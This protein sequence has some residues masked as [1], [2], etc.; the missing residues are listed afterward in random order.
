MSHNPTYRNYSFKCKPKE[1]EAGI[2]EFVRHACWQEGGSLSPIKWM[3][4][5]IFNSYEEAEEWLDKTDN[6]WY[7]NR[8][9]VYLDTSTISKPSKKLEDIERR[10]KEWRQRKSD[11]RSTYHFAEA[12]VSLIGCK[13]CGSKIA[14]E[15][16]RTRN[17]CPVCRKSMLSDTKLKQ[18]ER[19]DDMIAHL[20]KDYDTEKAVIHNKLL[21]KAEKRWLVY[22]DYHT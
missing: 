4:N 15:Y 6:G 19:A 16:M 21:N 17:D 20:Q 18:L 7:D 5:K 22:F 8:A 3:E 9:V 12:K 2:A 13:S 11:I 10:L 1:I 14:V